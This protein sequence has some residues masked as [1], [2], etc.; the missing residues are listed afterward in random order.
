MLGASR[1]ELRITVLA[2]GDPAIREGWKEGERD[3]EGIIGSLMVTQL[4][5]ELRLKPEDLGLVLRREVVQVGTVDCVQPK[6]SLFHRQVRLALQQQCPQVQDLGLLC[7]SQLGHGQDKRVYKQAVCFWM[8][9]P[10]SSLE[11]RKQAMCSFVARL[12]NTSA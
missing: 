7:E 3:A 9:M 4:V 10:H 11:P 8:S 6:A 12:K 1:S 2:P 5:Q